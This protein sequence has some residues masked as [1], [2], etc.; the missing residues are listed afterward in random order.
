[1]SSTNLSILGL[2]LYDDSIFANLEVPQGVDK[3]AVT[4]NILMECAE[5]EVVYPDFDFMKAAIGSWSAKQLPIWEKLKETTEYE[6]NPIWNKDGSIIERETTVRAT[7]A[8][9][10]AETTGHSAS[11]SHG[12]DATVK[13]LAAYD[14]SS[15][16][17]ADKTDSTLQTAENG[18]TK[19]ESTGEQSGSENY[20]R[21]YER[22][23]KGNIGV[24]TTQQMIKEQR[25][26]VLFNIV[27]T[28]VNDFKRRFCLLIY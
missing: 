14:S 3:S 2:Y 13:T 19:S 25:E 16:E 15:F 5:L 7:S 12:S 20:A 4:D 22:I 8:D 1:M 27:D 9:S 24:T 10:R 18:E 28:I 21:S 6:Y 11:T 23:E 17:N 26:V